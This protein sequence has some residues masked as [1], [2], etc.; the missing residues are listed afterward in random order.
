[1]SRSRRNSDYQCT[2][3]LPLLA[4]AC[5]MD[6]QLKVLEFLC[7]LNQEILLCK[8]FGE[9]RIDFEGCYQ[10]MCDSKGLQSFPP[11]SSYPIRNE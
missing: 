10:N 8:Y 2:S 9:R 11:C 7:D 5:S 1:M 3:T 4:R 6:A